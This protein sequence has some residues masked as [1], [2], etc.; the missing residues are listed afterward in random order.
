MAST[1]SLPRPS[2][3]WI[4]WYIVAFFVALISILVPMGIIAVRTHTGVVT[5]DAYEKGL[6]YN[7]S[8]QAGQQQA[9]MN[10]HGDL[11][12]TPSAGNTIMARFHLVDSA[13]KPL[14]HATVTLWLV[15]PMQA[16]FDQ[17]MA[18][19]A[20]PDGFYE[21]KTTLPAN[22]Q[23]EARVSALADGH[24]YQLVK[25]VVAP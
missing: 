6:A 3:R 16:G 12:L 21:A 25:R 22:G 9:A 7:K 5:E 4:P 11:T 23:W 1:S 24:D 19:M 18:M 13:N 2:D 20:E 10:W 17:K 8:I 14:R 15:R